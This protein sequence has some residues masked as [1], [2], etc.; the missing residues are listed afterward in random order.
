MISDFVIRDGEVVSAYQAHF[1]RCHNTGFPG[2]RPAPF[3]GIASILM[4]NKVH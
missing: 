3:C 2:Y 4:R 1:D